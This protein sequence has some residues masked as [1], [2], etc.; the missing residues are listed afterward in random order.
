M[1]PLEDLSRV[2]A[3]HTDGV[4][5][6]FDLVELELSRVGANGGGHERLPRWVDL[7]LYYARSDRLSGEFC[8]NSP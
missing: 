5:M 8:L 1:N 6:A 4:E 3:G 2:K 7:Q